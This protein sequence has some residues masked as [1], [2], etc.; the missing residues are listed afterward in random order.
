MIAKFSRPMQ[1]ILLFQKLMY[2]NFQSILQFQKKTLIQN[3]KSLYTNGLFQYS[4]ILS[5]FRKKK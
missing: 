3:Y 5:L 2:P 4:I 1:V